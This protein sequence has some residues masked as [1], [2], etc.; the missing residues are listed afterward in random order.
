MV[1]E[2]LLENGAKPNRANQLGVTPLIAAARRGKKDVVKVLLQ[3]GADVNAISLEVRKCQFLAVCITAPWQP[4]LLRFRGI[5]L[6]ELLATSM[7]SACRYTQAGLHLL[8]ILLRMLEI[9]FY[10]TSRLPGLLWRRQCT[11]NTQRS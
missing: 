8:S 2:Y 5:M 6:L 3:H 10:F 4:V 11:E 1:T 7:Q 9:R